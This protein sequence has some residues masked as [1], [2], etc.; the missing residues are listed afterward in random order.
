MRRPGFSLVEMLVSISIIGILVA[1]LLPAVQSAR[2][3]ARRSQCANNLKQL[4]LGLQQFHDINRQLPASLNQPVLAQNRVWTPQ[5]QTWSYL[6]VLLPYIEQRPLY[7]NFLSQICY[8]TTAVDVQSDFVR[9]GVEGLICPSEVQQFQ[10]SLSVAAATSYHANLGDFLFDN[11]SLKYR[12]AFGD[13]KGIVVSYSM[14]RDGLSNTAA[15]SETKIG[16]PFDRRV[17][18]GFSQKA[19]LSDGSPPKICL[20]MIDADGL[21]IGNLNPDHIVGFAW[22]DGQHGSTGY[23]HL[24]P[25]NGPSCG[26]TIERWPLV[27]AGSYHTAGVNICMLDGSVRFIGNNIDVGDSWAMNQG[28]ISPYGVWGAM[29]SV[30][31]GEF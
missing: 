11:Y 1:L 14:V 5:S 12:G 19:P 25:P 8:A 15:I 16:I 27:T 18:I 31:G 26:L 29:G 28:G 17:S 20:Q 30:A 9:H 24:L 7:D 4:G 13:G 21:L 3:T 23:F 2:E 6:V 10:P 22:T